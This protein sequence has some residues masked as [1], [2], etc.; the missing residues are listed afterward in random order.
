[1]SRVPSQILKKLWLWDLAS[2]DS[3]TPMSRSV[4]STESILSNGGQ[5][6]NRRSTMISRKST[7]MSLEQVW[8]D[9]RLQ[10]ERPIFRR[11]NEAH[12]YDLYLGIDV[13]E[14]P[15]LMMLSSTSSFSTWRSSSIA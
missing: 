1:M 3:T 9:L 11:V 14:G 5:C 15:V 7:K 12:P 4:S 13:Q 2:R 10:R 6:S 8:N